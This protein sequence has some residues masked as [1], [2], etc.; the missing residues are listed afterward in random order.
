MA[1][2]LCVFSFAVIL[3][4]VA[5]E[6]KKLAIGVSFVALFIFLAIR[7]DF[8]NDYSGYERVHWIVQN[9]GMMSRWLTY[10]GCEA[11]SFLNFLFDDFYVMIA[12]ISFLYC[13]IVYRLIT[14][15]CEKKYWALS[16]FVLTFNPYIL[17]MHAS[18]LRQTMAILVFIV[19]VDFAYRKK[20]IAYFCL[21]YVATL[22]HSSAVILYP[23]YFLL[24]FDWKESFMLA[25]LTCALMV[26]FSGGA[27]VNFIS[28]ISGDVIGEGMTEHYIDASNT[29]RATVLSS[30]YLIFMLFA[31]PEA[32][33]K[34]AIYLRLG[35]VSALCAVVALRVSMFTRIQMYFEIFTIVAIP[36]AFKSIKAPKFFLIS[37]ELYRFS[38]IALLIIIYFLRVYSFF[39]NPLWESFVEYQTI[40]QR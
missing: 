20:M 22:F 39:T 4:L 15:N 21:I 29:V 7:Y 9:K 5:K 8:G 30:L 6:H 25:V 3:P 2:A 38:W 23:V 37:N 12:F 32:E 16:V 19:A 28:E 27:V 24:C 14:N 13:Y 40:F 10:R 11:Y 34:D 18:A 35:I 33:G 26:I 36:V 31:Y 1:I 17:L